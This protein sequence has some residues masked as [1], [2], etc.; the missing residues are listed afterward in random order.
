MS[1]GCDSEVRWWG[2]ELVVVVV[3]VGGQRGRRR[4]QYMEL[5]GK[6]TA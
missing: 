5:R 4:V 1:Y 6:K 2:W 3:A